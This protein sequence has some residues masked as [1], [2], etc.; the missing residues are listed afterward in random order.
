MKGYMKAYIK[1]MSLKESIDKFLSKFNSSPPRTFFPEFIWTQSQ[2]WVTPQK[3]Y[4]LVNGFEFFK[5]KK[6]NKPNLTI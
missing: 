6:L 5:Q 4:K 1:V 2:N 3:T